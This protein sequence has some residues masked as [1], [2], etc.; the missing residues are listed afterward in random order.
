[1]KSMVCVFVGV[2]RHQTPV[3]YESVREYIL[4]VKAQDGGDPPLSNTAV[5]KINITDSNDNAPVFPQPK[6]HVTVAED[7]PV[8]ESLVRVRSWSIMIGHLHCLEKITG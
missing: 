8:G 1:M 5:L 3:D 4:T 2:L 7:A 6:Y